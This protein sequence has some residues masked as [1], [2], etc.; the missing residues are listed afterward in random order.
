MLPHTRTARLLT[1]VIRSDSSSIDAN[2]RIPGGHPLVVAGSAPAFLGIELG[3][4][5]AA[6]LE[7]LAR[8]GAGDPPMRTGRLARVREAIFLLERLPAETDLRVVAELEGAAPPLAIYRI[9]VLVEGREAIRATI[10]THAGER[11]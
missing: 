7:G 1:S 10:S 5:A 4:Q 11:S 9:R 8:A 3:A 2:G 6:A